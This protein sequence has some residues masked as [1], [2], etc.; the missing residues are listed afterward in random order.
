MQE[1]RGGAPG[2]TRGGVWVQQ[3]AAGTTSWI[4]MFTPT[5]TAH[6]LE[7]SKTAACGCPARRS[8]KVV[9]AA[10]ETDGQPWW[11]TSS[12]SLA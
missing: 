6:S 9:T 4:P 3:V 12:T 1:L 11:P 2:Q 10:N 8:V 5:L 7:G